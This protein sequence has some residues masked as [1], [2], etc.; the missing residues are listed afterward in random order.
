MPGL[1]T[2]PTSLP[3]AGL[4]PSTFAN[5]QYLHM[6]STCRLGPAIDSS[7]GIMEPTAKCS[8]AGKSRGPR[9]FSLAPPSRCLTAPPTLVAS[10]NSMTAQTSLEPDDCH[11]TI[12]I[13]M[14]LSIPHISV[15]SPYQNLIALSLG[16]VR[17]LPDDLATP[18]AINT[19][20][21]ASRIGILP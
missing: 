11:R 18:A 4:P 20:A 5:A 2:A 14:L 21:P 10:T 9:R 3:S 13:P 15:A 17:H 7:A 16:R 8:A 6:W 1:P 19:T 12:T